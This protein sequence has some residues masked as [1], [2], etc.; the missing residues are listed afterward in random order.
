MKYILRGEVF[1]T[2]G[3]TICQNCGD[4]PME[5]CE[6]VKVFKT[7]PICKAC[8]KDWNAYYESPPPAPTERH[9]NPAPMLAR[10]IK[11]D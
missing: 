4:C 6:M 2:N 9:V 1:I 3:D 7:K 10:L 8:F 5:G 11:K